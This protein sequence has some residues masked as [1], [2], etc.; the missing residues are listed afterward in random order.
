[1]NTL[2]N[3]AVAAVLAGT[4]L[5]LGTLGEILTEKSGNLN[6][7]VEGMMFMGAIAGLAAPYAYE[8]HVLD[9]GGTP[10]GWVGALLA[11]AASWLCGALGALIYAFLTIT[12]RADQNVTGL[13]LAIFGT[14]FGNFFGEYLGS[15]AG[16]YVALGDEVKSAFSNLSIPG[17]YRIP[18]LGKLLFQ[19]N[20]VVYFAI[21]LALLLDWFLKKTRVGLNLRAVGEDPAAADAAGISVSRYRYAATAIGGGICGIGGMYMSMVTTSCVWVH[22]CVSGYGWLAVALVIFAAWSPARALLAALVFGGLT[23]LRLYFHI[24]GIPMQ[25]YEMLPYVATILV[26]VVSSVRQSRE[27]AQ[28]KSCGVNYFREER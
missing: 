7:G 21:A 19:Y 23:V 13:T 16:G 2:L 17:L 28:P 26:L 14:G 20:W 24:P 3:L 15:Q 27:N 9:A 5:L 11:L 10:S 25:I 4:P 12:L 6:L 8:Q 22:D 18:V 1:M